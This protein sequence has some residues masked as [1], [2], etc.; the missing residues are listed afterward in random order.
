MAQIDNSKPLQTTLVG[1]SEKLQNGA[2]WPFQSISDHF[3]RKISKNLEN[4][5]NW[6][7][8]T[9]LVERSWKSCK[10]PKLVVTNHFGPL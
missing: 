6:P 1:K 10:T 2:N 3:N 8:Q 9:I 5:Q 4:D 7:F